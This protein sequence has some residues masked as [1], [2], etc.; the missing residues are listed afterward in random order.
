MIFRSKWR[1]KTDQFVYHTACAP[2]VCFFIILFFMHL[3][4]THVIWGSNVC[5][6]HALALL[7]I[8]LYYPGQ[9]KVAKLHIIVLIKENVAWFQISVQDFGIL[10]SIVT[11]SERKKYLHKDFPHN[12]FWYEIF[13]YLVVFDEFGH[14]TV[15]AVLH[16]NEYF[17]L[18]PLVYLLNV[19]HDVV[20][21]KLAQTVDLTY[22]LRSFFFRQ[23]SIVY[24]FP[25]IQL[26]T[27]IIILL[28]FID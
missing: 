20:V 14:V 5:L 7:C 17:L 12:I 21:I 10:Y 3:F 25:A 9:S 13:L 2:Y 6:G 11:F 24:F 26:A 4:W 28:N 8:A 16:H 15:F 23:M 27:C 19:L 1:Q 22:Y 18:I